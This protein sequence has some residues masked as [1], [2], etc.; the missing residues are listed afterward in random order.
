MEEFGWINKQAYHDQII[1]GETIWI[2][3]QQK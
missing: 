2:K 3:K 1:K